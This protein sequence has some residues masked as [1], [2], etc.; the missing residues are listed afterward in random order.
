M[1]DYSEKALDHFFNPRNAG[2]LEAANAVGSVG[3]LEGGDAV[4][5]MLRIDPD[6]R[7]IAEARFQAFGGGDAIAA[8]SALTVLVTGQSVDEARRLTAGQIDAALGGLPG[9]RKPAADLAQ[10][11]LQAALAQFLGITPE[12]PKP[13][14]K[15]ASVTL[16][17]P[18]HES[19]PKI[20]REVPLSPEDEATIIAQVIDSVRPTLRADGGDVTL[21]AVEGAKVRVHLTGNCSGC[22]LA[23]L[24]L[25]GLQKRLADALGR[26]IRVIPEQ[27]PLVSIAG[28]R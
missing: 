17:A 18:R 23:A 8:C 20:L 14:P 28:A 13:D 4:R 11:A 27:K 12:A 7:V 6:S 5:L 22:Q 2:V 21:V 25:G 9:D 26:P 16:L 15:P 3:S 19:K 10:A 24:T 1:L